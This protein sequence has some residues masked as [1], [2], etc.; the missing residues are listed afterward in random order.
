MKKYYIK[1]EDCRD[2]GWAYEIDSQTYD[3]NLIV[4]NLGKCLVVK[5]DQ[6]VEGYQI[7]KGDQ[8]V[9]GS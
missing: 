1:K 2:I 3:G 8:I 4:E 7:V 9:E 5:G 6:I